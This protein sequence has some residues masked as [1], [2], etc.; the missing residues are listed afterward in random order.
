[1]TFGFASDPIFEEGLSRFRLSAWLRIRSGSG[2]NR[3][4]GE[5][6]RRL[7]LSGFLPR[8]E[9]K[10]FKGPDPRTQRLQTATRDVQH[11][12]EAPG[13]N[14]AEGVTHS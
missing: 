6:L 2:Q 4:G 3:F 8:L 5:G 7:P 13:P 9:F 10:N 14:G 11:C 12:T 1:M